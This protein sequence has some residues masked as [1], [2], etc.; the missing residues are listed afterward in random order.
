MYTIC[1]LFNFNKL[2]SDLD[3]EI[4]TTDS[5][6]C[7]DSKYV[8]PAAGHVITGNLKLISDSWIRSITAK[9]PI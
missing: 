9:G 6:D 2:V 4:S 1:R 7:K 5:W 8:Y 3:I